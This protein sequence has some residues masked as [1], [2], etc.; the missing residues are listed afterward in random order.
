MTTERFNALPLGLYRVYWKQISGGGMSLAA[1]G[2]SKDGSRW[3]APINWVAPATA[4]NETCFD[5]ARVE[6]VETCDGSDHP[7][8]LPN[9]DCRDCGVFVTSVPG[10]TKG[11]TVVP[12]G[13]SRC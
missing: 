12:R 7:F 6:K 5:I 1:I 2:M 13:R 10:L 9:G 3:I 4:S 11:H 8:V